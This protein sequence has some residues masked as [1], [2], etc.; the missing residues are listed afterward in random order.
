MFSVSCSSKLKE[1]LAIKNDEI[2]RLQRELKSSNSE[3]SKLKQNQNQKDGL[4]NTAVIED[5]DLFREL[6]ISERFRNSQVKINEVDSTSIKPLVAYR[7]TLRNE[8][9]PNSG[10]EGYQ[11]SGTI[12]INPELKF[13]QLVWSNM[14][15]VSDFPPHTFYFIDFNGDGEKD[16]IQYSGFEDVFDTEIFINR[17]KGN[18]R[19]LFRSVFRN[20][21]NYSSIID[22]DHDGSPEIINVIDQVGWSPTPG[23]NIPQSTIALIE[24]EYDRIIGQYDQFTFRYGMPKVY[25]QFAVNLMDDIEILKISGDSII[26][27]SSQFPSHFDFRLKALSTIKVESDEMKSWISKLIEKAESYGTIN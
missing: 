9:D 5:S 10:Y 4:S 6:I 25:K 19:E 24:K 14:D 26:N 17:T 15:L 21:I 2:K 1:E 13:N 27:V 7:I 3:L 8:N 16:L 18:N 23:Y 22:L 11:G 20:D 12:I